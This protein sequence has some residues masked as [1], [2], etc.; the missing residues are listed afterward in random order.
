MSAPCSARLAVCVETPTR[1]YCRGQGAVRVPATL[2]RPCA[3]WLVAWGL[4][5]EESEPVPEWTKRAESHRLPA[6]VFG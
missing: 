3:E 5:L 4:P 1:T 2:C 6:K